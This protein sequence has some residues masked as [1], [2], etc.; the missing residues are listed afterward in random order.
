M[1]KKL[2]GK[3]EFTY[4]NQKTELSIFEY[5]Q[6]LYSD[7]YDLQDT[8]A[9]YIVAKALGCKEPYNTGSWTLYDIAYRNMRI[10]VKETS[11]FHSWQTDEE[12]KSKQRTF[13][14]TKAYSVYQDNSSELVRQNDLYIFCLNTGETRNDSNP[15]ELE[16]WEFYIIPTSTINDLCGDQKTISLSRIRTMTEKVDYIHLKDKV[17]EI[18]DYIKKDSV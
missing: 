13:G 8:I 1:Y 18:I 4:H 11:F 3:E 16:H 12:P 7:I 17:D 10:E 14:I 15:L 9:E 2:S 5:W 6:W